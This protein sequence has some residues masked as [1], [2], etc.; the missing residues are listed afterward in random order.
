MKTDYLKFLKVLCSLFDGEN[1]VPESEIRKKWKCCPS[2]AAILSFGKDVYFEYNNEPSS[3]GYI[4]T[5]RGMDLISDSK[6]SRLTLIISIA[7][8]IVA[9]LTL[10]ATII[11]SL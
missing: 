11:L 7:T 4:P 10:V 3:P 5:V 8:L 2:H 6:R 9:V 1:Y